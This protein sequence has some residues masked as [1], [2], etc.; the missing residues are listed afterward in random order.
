MKLICI[1]CHSFQ[2]LIF[3]TLLLFKIL[4]FFRSKKSESLFSVKFSW[5][6]QE[7]SLLTIVSVTSLFIEDISFSRYNYEYTFVNKI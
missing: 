5:H 3:Q 7:Q 4:T 1:I 2:S 6:S